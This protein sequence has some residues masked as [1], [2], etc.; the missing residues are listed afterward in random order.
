MT[1]QIFKKQVPIETLFKLLGAICVKDD[2]YYILTNDSFKKGLFHDF[3]SP[4]FAECFEYYHVSKRVYLERKLTYNS[5]LTVVRQ[6]CKHNHVAY[7]SQIK[8]DKSNYNIVY[9]I[10]YK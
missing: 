6:I 1:T 2:K 8:Y 4:F 7:T 3:I 5:F 10:Y 9:N